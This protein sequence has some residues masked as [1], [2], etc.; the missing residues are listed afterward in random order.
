VHLKQGA[1]VPIDGMFVRNNPIGAIYNIE[2]VV[3]IPVGMLGKQIGLSSPT[4]TDNETFY[5]SC[6]LG[7]CRTNI[8][9][10][11]VGDTISI[12]VGTNI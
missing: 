9:Y 10:F 6:T 7:Y 11:C 4:R 1:Q 12:P 8:F 3:D 5:L 2:A